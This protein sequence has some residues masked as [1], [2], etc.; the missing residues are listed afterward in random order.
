LLNPVL[1]KICSLWL[2]LNGY[3][4]RHCIEWNNITLQD[5][6]DLADARLKN[7]QAAQLEQ[8]LNKNN[9]KG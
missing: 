7:A 6:M 3:D 1:T 4:S 9:G 5:E 2:R 8:S